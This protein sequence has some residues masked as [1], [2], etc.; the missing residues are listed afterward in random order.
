MD[1]LYWRGYDALLGIIA[2]TRIK[3]HTTVCSFILVSKIINNKEKEHV[4]PVSSNLPVEKDGFSIT[5]PAN[6]VTIVVLDY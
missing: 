2:I 3:E 4:V 1:R 5:L 6:S